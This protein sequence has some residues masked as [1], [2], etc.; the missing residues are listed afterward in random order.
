VQK[1]NCPAAY[2]SIAST[3]R[4]TRLRSITLAGD[5]AG[6]TGCPARVRL[7]GM[8]G[9]PAGRVAL[10]LGGGGEGDAP[11]DREHASELTDAAG[12]AGREMDASPTTTAVMP[13]HQALSRQPEATPPP[14]C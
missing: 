8:S 11:G 3:V 2:C 12:H 14:G 9:K 5:S 10:E 4:P 7:D 13:T 6:Q 1:G